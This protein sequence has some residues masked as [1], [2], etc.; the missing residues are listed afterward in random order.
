MWSKRAATNG[1]IAALACVNLP[2]EITHANIETTSVR[3]TERAFVMVITAMLRL[4][5]KR[6]HEGW[7][8]FTKHET[9]YAFA[10]AF[11]FKSTL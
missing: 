5:K 7:I 4:C 6:K 8:R 2:L 9:K 11:S 3:H 1:A 10:Y